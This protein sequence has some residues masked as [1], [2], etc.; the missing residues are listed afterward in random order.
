[1]KRQF[2]F[3]LQDKVFKVP[4]GQIPPKALNAIWYILHPTHFIQDRW[5]HMKYDPM[6]DTYTINGVRI[7]GNII[8]ELGRSR[9][10][11]IEIRRVNDRWRLHF[12]SKPDNAS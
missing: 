4:G 6:T 11:A 10:S 9:T 7:S 12:I 3:W 2:Y 8:T 5:S 1:M